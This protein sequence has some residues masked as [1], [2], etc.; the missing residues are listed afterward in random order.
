MFAVAVAATAAAES[1]LNF[2]KESDLACV[3]AT[4]AADV[5]ASPAVAPLADAFFS[6]ATAGLLPDFLKSTAVGGRQL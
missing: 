2:A 4:V 5:S 3:K 1:A 6:A